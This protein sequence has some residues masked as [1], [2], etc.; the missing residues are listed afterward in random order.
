MIRFL[1]HLP[2]I[3]ARYRRH[4][5]AAVIPEVRAAPAKEV[6]ADVAAPS[7]ATVPFYENLLTD[8]E[9][10]V[11]KVAPEMLAV[12][13]LPF[14]QEGVGWM[15]HRE[16]ESVGG[17]MADQLGMGK[18]VQM[19]ALCVANAEKTRLKPASGTATATSPNASRPQKEKSKVAASSP[20]TATSTSKAEVVV[21]PIKPPKAHMNGSTAYIGY[22]IITVIQQMMHI[23][24][25]G[26]CSKLLRPGK[27]LFDLMKEVERLVANRASKYDGAYADLEPWLLLCGRHQ[28]SF[29]RRARLFLCDVTTQSLEDLS[30]PDLRT[31]IVVPASLIYQWKG[32]IE[33]KISPS[34]GTRIHVFHGDGKNASTGDLE[35]Y[36][37]VLASYD[38]VVTSARKMFENSGDSRAS[39]SLKPKRWAYQ[40]TQPRDPSFDRGSAGPLHQVH[41]KRIILDEAHLIRHATTGRWRAIEQLQAVKKWIV[42]A[43][44]LHNTIE[45]LQNLL[46]FIEAPKLPLVT[47]ASAETMLKDAALQ[48]SVARSLQTVFLRRSPVMF[49]HGAREV[50]VELPPKNDMLRS[51]D[52]SEEE[53]RQYNEILAKSRSEITR[54]VSDSKVCHVFAMMTRLRQT[55]CHPW[56]SEGKAVQLYRCDICGNEATN[57]VVAKCGHAFCHECLVGRY[58]QVAVNGEVNFPCPECQAMLSVSLLKGPAHQSSAVHIAALKLR[59]FKSS[60]KLDMIMSEVQTVLKNTVDDKLVIFS[61][62]TTFLDIVQLAF[63][64]EAIPFGRL[65]GMMTLRERA[66]VQRRFHSVGTFRVLLASKLASGVGLN[67]TAANHVIIVDPWWNPAIEEQAI[68]RCHRIG[69]KKPVHVQRLITTDTIEQYCHEIAQRKKDFADAVLQAATEQG[70]QRTRILSRLDEIVDRLHFVKNNTVRG[71]AP[72]SATA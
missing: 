69:Q 2:K 27:D 1:Q 72:T 66:D 61:H 22:K 48:R 56:L 40:K 13:L 3:A 31:L 55:C 38:S 59:P 29:E 45:D 58:H 28:P 10:P 16:K 36:D 63:E 65:D 33:A 41:W 5:P 64:R 4:F 52:L 34:F 70:P 25:I 53:S 62:F 8:E 23:S 21:T 51:S 32:E 60:T 17:I 30:S 44:P 71:V 50:L 15:L 14:Q 12:N 11:A 68:H 49:R 39:T 24:A 67:L 6:D 9:L 35:G 42:T 37:F 47:Q 54:S 18:T 7:S 20:K 19:I 43:T 26:G 46:S 57:P